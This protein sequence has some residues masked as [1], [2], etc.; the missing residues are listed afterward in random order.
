M[1]H[2]VPHSPRRL[3]RRL[4]PSLAATALVLGL[5]APAAAD[6]SLCDKRIRTGETLGSCLEL[7]VDGCFTLPSSFLGIHH[8]GLACTF[9]FASA[10]G[11]FWTAEEIAEEPPEICL[12]ESENVELALWYQCSCVDCEGPPS[13]SIGVYGIDIGSGQ[14]LTTPFVESV[15]P[16]SV[17]TN[18]SASAPCWIERT[19]EAITARAQV[20]SRAFVQWLRAPEGR[21]LSAPLGFPVALYESDPCDLPTGL[22]RSGGCVQIPELERP[23]EWVVRDRG[24]LDVDRICHYVSGGRGK[25]AL[26]LDRCPGCGGEALCPNWR[27]TLPD[28]GDRVDVLVHEGRSGRVIARGRRVGNDLVIE[29]Q[30]KIKGALEPGQ[31]YLSFRTGGEATGR[32]AVPIRPHLDFVRPR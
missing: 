10:K 21:E 15:A 16:L 18:C 28:V 29:F 30:P 4:S 14:L 25:L 7:P 24:I 5:A 8:E 32:D 11:D 6:L 20:G 23:L 3:L 19:A 1:P 13:D 31:Y 27:I 2:S 12:D 22:L 9:S 17:S 26:S